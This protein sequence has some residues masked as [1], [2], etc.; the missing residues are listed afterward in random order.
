[1]IAAFWF[2]NLDPGSKIWRE[3]SK[4][5]LG[6]SGDEHHVL[7]TTLPSNSSPNEPL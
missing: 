5:M 7:R 1:L 3:L 2:H 6:I 4:A